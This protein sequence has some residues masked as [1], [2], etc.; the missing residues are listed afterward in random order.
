MALEVRR[1]AT[2]D[3]P[4]ADKIALRKEIEESLGYIVAA[5]PRGDDYTPP[6]NAD[7]EAL[8]LRGYKGAVSGF[9]SVAKAKKG[10]QQPPSASPVHAAQSTLSVLPSSSASAGTSPAVSLLGCDDD[11]QPQLTVPVALP[12]PPVHTRPVRRCRTQ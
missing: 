10:E 7:R 2:F 1:Y 8:W 11:G 5:G 6:K 3:Q 12:T 4:L 9:H